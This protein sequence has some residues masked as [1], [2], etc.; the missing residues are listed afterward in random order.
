VLDRF[1]E[2]PA[3]VEPSPLEAP[4]NI[5]ADPAPALQKVV[6]GFLETLERSAA[7]VA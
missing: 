6:E 1:I 4:V 7:R 3:P 5:H 2:S